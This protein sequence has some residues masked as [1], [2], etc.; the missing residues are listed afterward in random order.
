[1]AARSRADRTRR[2]SRL[3]APVSARS[4]GAAAR[5][6]TRACSGRGSCPRSSPAPGC[7]PCITWCCSRRSRCVSRGWPAGSVTDSPTRPPPVLC[8]RSSPA[9]RWTGA[10]SSRP[11]RGTPRPPRPRFSSRVASGAARYPEVISAARGLAGAGRRP[12]RR[13][14]PARRPRRCSRRRRRSP[15]TLPP[16]RVSM[17]TRVT[18]SVPCAAS[19]MRTRKSISS[20]FSSSGYTG[21]ERL[22]QRVVERV[23]RAVA[24]P[25]ATSRRP[26]AAQLDRRLATAS[27]PGR[28]SVM[29]RQLSTSK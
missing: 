18:A 13:P 29:T 6:S 23:D 17:R 14:G 8:T 1:M 11:G 24:L 21:S 2:S 10:T 5:S 9:P 26:P 22:A 27:P 4:A 3:P 7:R 20:S 15:T 12:G 19:R 28:D 25:V 16:S